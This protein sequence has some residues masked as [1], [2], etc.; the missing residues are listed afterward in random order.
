MFFQGLGH[1]L[2]VAMGL[3]A[4]QGLP[5]PAHPAIGACLACAALFGC[6]II[7]IALCGQD[8]PRTVHQGDNLRQLLFHSQETSQGFSALDCLRYR[9]YPFEDY[10]STH[11]STPINTIVL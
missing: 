9:A 6:E 8:Q 4:F 2:A 11:V 3:G 7:A 1:A 10:F 5:V